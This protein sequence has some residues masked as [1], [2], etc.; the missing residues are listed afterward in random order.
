MRFKSL[1]SSQSI[2]KDQPMQI[3]SASEDF[4]QRDCSDSYE[5]LAHQNPV[6]FDQHSWQVEQTL[7]TTNE[8]IKSVTLIL[9]SGLEKQRKPEILCLSIFKRLSEEVNAAI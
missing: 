5:A 9:P 4:K 2:K 6:R 8:T 3:K 1:I 7:P